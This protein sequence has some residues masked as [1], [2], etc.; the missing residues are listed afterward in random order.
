MGPQT[1]R[2][3]FPEAEDEVLEMVRSNFSLPSPR[4]RQLT[5]TRFGRSCSPIA[6]T[7]RARSTPCSRCRNS[8]QTAVPQYFFQ[9]RERNSN[10]RAKP[11]M[12]WAGCP[13]PAENH[14][15]PTDRHSDRHLRRMPTSAI[16]TKHKK[17]KRQKK[18][19]HTSQLEPRKVFVGDAEKVCPTFSRCGIRSKSD[20]QIS[21]QMNRK[22]LRKKRQAERKELARGAAVKV[23][24]WRGLLER[25]G[26]DPR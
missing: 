18:V 4:C 23:R 14:S 20:H 5:S 22:Q 3:I 15:L 17:R 7:C 24:R 16:D 13:R 1:L 10:R 26:A 2:G 6:A 19:K 25:L 8:I 9:V 12:W 11:G 21:G